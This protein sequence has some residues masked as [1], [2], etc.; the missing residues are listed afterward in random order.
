MLLTNKTAATYGGGGAIGRA[1]AKEGTKVFLAGRTPA[2]IKKTGEEIVASGR[3][4]E[5]AG[6]EIQVELVALGQA[7]ED[8]RCISVKI[9]DARVV[10]DGDV[11]TCGD[12]TSGLDLAFWFVE[13][14][15][16]G[17]IAQDVEEW[18]EYQRH[19]TI[20][21][22]SKRTQDVLRSTAKKSARLG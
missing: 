2:H 10:D 5:A 14:F 22:G 6:G 1:V 8:L 17:R 15:A 19:V 11:I 18:T 16:G 3:F 12:M 13:R 21:K 4:A 20:R 9:I 7:I